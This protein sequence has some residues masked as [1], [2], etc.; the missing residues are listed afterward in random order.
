MG[1]HYN[2]DALPNETLNPGLGS[3]VAHVPLQLG[4]QVLNLHQ[5]ARHIVEH[6]GRFD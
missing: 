3:A 4:L 5:L 6:P 2:M 1:K